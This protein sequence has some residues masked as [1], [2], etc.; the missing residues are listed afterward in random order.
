MGE[1]REAANSAGARRGGGRESREFRGPLQAQFWLEWRRNGWLL[2]GLTGFVALLAAAPVPWLIELAPPGAVRFAIGCALA[3]VALAVLVGKGFSVPDFWARDLSLPPFVAI[4]PLSCGEWVFVR[5]RI[6]AVSAG[7]SCLIMAAA[8][9]VA[10]TITGNWETLLAALSRAPAGFTP[11]SPWLPAVAAVLF[12]FLLTWRYLVV[13]LYAGLLGKQWPFVLA[14]IGSLT[15]LFFLEP[16]WL[17]RVWLDLTPYNPEFDWRPLVWLLALGW[18][19]K[20]LL[21]GW[22]WN[23]AL[24]RR[25]VSHSEIMRYFGFWLVAMLALTGCALLMLPV[26]NWL[27]QVSAFAVGLLLPLGRIGLAPLAF[28][29]NRHRRVSSKAPR[30][31]VQGVETAASARPAFAFSP[32][33]SAFVLLLAV[34]VALATRHNLR[35]VPQL[36]TANGQA[37]R[38]LVCGQG[39]PAI[40]L[41]GDM[42]AMLREWAPLQQSLARETTVFAYERPGIGGSPMGQGTG[43][44]LAQNAADLRELLRGRGIEGPVVLVGAHIGAA[45]ARAFAATAPERVA[46]LVLLDPTDDETSAEV[47]ADLRSSHPE[48]A[49]S[50]D[51]FLKE[52]DPIYRPYAIRELRL[53][54]RELAAS[55]FANLADVRK[56]RWED[57]RSDKVYMK[58]YQFTRADAGSRSEFSRLDELLIED[59]GHQLPDRPTTVLTGTKLGVGNMLEREG[60]QASRLDSKLASRNAWLAK[61][62]RATHVVVPDAGDDLIRYGTETVIHH[63]HAMVDQVKAQP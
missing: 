32:A 37:F 50:I 45:Y 58:T 16:W 49:G 28:A 21:A 60:M 31:S 51:I 23:E 22:A 62:P 4:R 44:S 25:L 26:D 30:K 52:I 27:R 35:D 34:A 12:A 39:S 5:L 46:G 3:P 6:A 1:R 55:G 2:P 36:V 18:T 53:I 17:S 24:R 9:T 61:H 63:V 13:S 33:V 41:E 10:L 56:M 20:L 19:G 57:L 59:R 29:S 42:E 11:R 54:E 40:V 7:V 43:R 8:L 48:L 38:V 14:T 47:L 15:L